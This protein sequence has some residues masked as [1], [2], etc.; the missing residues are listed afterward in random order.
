ML[1]KM[2]KT[3][4]CYGSVKMIRFSYSNE[5]TKDEEPKRSTGAGE[6]WSKPLSSPC[7]WRHGSPQD[8][9]HNSESASVKHAERHPAGGRRTN[10]NYPLRTSIA[11]KLGAYFTL[12]DPIVPQ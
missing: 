10:E 9:R 11:T 5:D 1:S 7:S 6:K 3:S 12:I 8:Q 4:E 2:L